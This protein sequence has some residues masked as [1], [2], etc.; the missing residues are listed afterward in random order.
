MFVALT[1]AVTP[2]LHLLGDGQVA[3]NVRAGMFRERMARRNG[4]VVLDETSE[5]DDMLPSYPMV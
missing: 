3:L 2:P 1:H 4:L 5:S